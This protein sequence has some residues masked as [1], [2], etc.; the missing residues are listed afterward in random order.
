MKSELGKANHV[1]S[2]IAAHIGMVSYHHV[3]T[4]SYF[5]HPRGRGETATEGARE[6]EEK[7]RKRQRENVKLSGLFL[8]IPPRC[9]SEKLIFCHL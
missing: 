8:A 9:L 2:K 4:K 1:A 6:R 7:K 5:H 3:I